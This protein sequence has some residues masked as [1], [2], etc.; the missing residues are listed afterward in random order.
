MFSSIETINISGHKVNNRIEF[1][2]EAETGSGVIL[3]SEVSIN[4]DGDRTELVMQG[5][6]L[7]FEKI[8]KDMEDG[9]GLDY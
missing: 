5:I 7:C 3:S 2:V 6:R 4:L 9:Y 8:D 1:F